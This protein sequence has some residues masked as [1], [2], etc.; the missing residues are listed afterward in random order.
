MNAV[1]EQ[2]DES[3]DL[4]RGA[5]SRKSREVKPPV[6]NWRKQGGKT[7]NWGLLVDC[8]VA[9]IIGTFALIMIRVYRVLDPIFWGRVGFDEWREYHPDEQK[10][11]HLLIWFFLVVTSLML[12]VVWRHFKIGYL[13]LAAIVIMMP[14]VLFF[15]YPREVG[16]YA[17]PVFGP[18]LDLLED[19]IPW[20]FSRLP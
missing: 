10:I 4:E 1:A 6:D 17:E 11:Y 5:H 14:G 8:V 16:M 19:F 2:A 13:V 12:V 15:F 18:I 9:N 20:L 3:R 7:T